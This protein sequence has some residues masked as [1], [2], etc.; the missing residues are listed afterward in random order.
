MKGEIVAKQLTGPERERAA[1]L[2]ALFSVLIHA[3]ITHDFNDAQFAKRELSK[4]GIVIR[5][6]RASESEVPHAK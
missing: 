4:A 3:W 6:R 1:H 5:F 2:V